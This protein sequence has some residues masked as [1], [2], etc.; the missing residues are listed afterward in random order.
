[1]AKGKQ[2]T[3]AP[4]TTRATRSSTTAATRAV[5]AAD[6]KL[7][8]PVVNAAR[9][10]GMSPS[11]SQRCYDSRTTDAHASNTKEEERADNH[12]RT[13]RGRR[14]SKESVNTFLPSPSP[15]LSV[16]QLES[17]TSTLP[18]TASNGTGDED[19]ELFQLLSSYYSHSE[20]MCYHSSRKHHG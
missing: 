12:V 6:P 14:T 18:N 16:S 7:T 5:N 1:M 19:S 8:E 20:S 2:K 9:P 11:L 4:P 10:K 13:E 15:W 3:T 17:H